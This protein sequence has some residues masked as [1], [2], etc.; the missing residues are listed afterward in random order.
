MLCMVGVGGGFAA[1]DIYFSGVAL[2]YAERYTRKPKYNL[3]IGYT[4]AILARA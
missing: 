4:Y 3:H 2:G 1:P